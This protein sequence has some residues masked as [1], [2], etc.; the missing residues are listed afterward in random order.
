[1]II[2]QGD[3]V[4]AEVVDV[5]ENGIYLRHDD[6]A[7]FVNVTN[8][9]WKHGRVDPSSYAKKGQC[10]DVIVYAVAADRFYASIKD[11]HPENNPWKDPSVYAVESHHTGTVRTVAPFGAFVE[12]DAGAVGYLAGTPE[13]HGLRAGMR[14]DVDIVA[15]DPV[16]QKVE[17]R[18]SA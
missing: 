17:L 14:V 9:T 7:G 1:M 15:M 2:K 18:I 4:R 8:I 13:W 3:I 10:V 12:L 11:L 5:K 6:A 16:L